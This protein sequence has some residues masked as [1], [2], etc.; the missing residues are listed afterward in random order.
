MLGIRSAPFY[1]HPG[2]SSWNFSCSHWPQNRLAP[3]PQSFT[4]LLNSHANLLH[5]APAVVFQK[6][7][8]P[9][10]AGSCALK[11][12]HLWLFP[13]I[14]PHPGSGNPEAIFSVAQWEWAAVCLTE[15]HKDWLYSGTGDWWFLCLPIIYLCIYL[16]IYSLGEKAISCSSELKSPKPNLVLRFLK[17]Y[18]FALYSLFFKFFDIITDVTHFS[19]LCSSPHRPF[20]PQSYCFLCPW[21]MCI[22]SLAI[23]FTF[24]HSG[25]STHLPSNICQIVSCIPNS[26]SF[27]SV[28]FVH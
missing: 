2:K 13:F 25:W 3:L 9:C 1:P 20:L 21:V 17:L 16:S 22:N 26:G 28:Y 23:L 18:W 24:F 14:S 19:P 12:P 11:C 7:Q 5:A 10:I 6:L 15:V 4:P 27:L 8:L